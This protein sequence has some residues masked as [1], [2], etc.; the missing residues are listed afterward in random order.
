MSKKPLQRAAARLL[1]VAVLAV[2]A[3]IGT[4]VSAFAASGGTINTGGGSANLRNGPGT[5]YAVIGSIANGTAVSVYC[6][7]YGTWITG[8]FGQTNVWD[9]IGGGRWVTDA[10]VNTGTNQPIAMPCSDWNGFAAGSGSVVVND[11]PSCNFTNGGGGSNYGT[12]NDGPD[13]WLMSNGGCS[14]SYYW[15]W[16][17]GANPSGVD[18][19]RW[20]YFPGAYAHCT[21]TM[22]I[23]WSS[24]SSPFTGRA[25]YTIYTNHASPTAIGSATINQSATQGQ[26]VT[27]GTWQA[28]G[29]GYLRVRMDDSST[30]TG[31]L[32]VA[33]SAT[34]YCTGSY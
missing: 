9:E 27:L 6:I 31:Q 33:N 26:D 3:V 21:I 12:A 22:H 13:W 24:S 28:D 4:A 19:V 11:A 23:P 18:Y 20:G 14:N 34:F 16:G 1:A 8:P 5:N 10:F 17:N 30:A 25:S 7:G 2:A 32:V 29:S 15:T